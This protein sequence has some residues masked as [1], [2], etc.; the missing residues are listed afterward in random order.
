MML[1]SIAIASMVIG[2]QIGPG[3]DCT[4]PKTPEPVERV[5][6]VVYVG[7]SRMNGMEIHTGKGGDFVVA[8]DCMGYSWLKEAVPYK[9]EQL[10]RSNPDIKEWTIVSN[11]GVNDLHDIEQYILLY[12][13]LESLGF[14]VVVM[15]VNPT[16][17]K[18]NDLN[19]EIDEF[20]SRLKECGVEYFDMCSHLREVGYSTRDGLH[21]DR[22]TNIEIW[23]EL[24]HYL[25][26]ES[27]DDYSDWI[28]G[29]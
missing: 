5:E 21:Y 2:L 28:C 20:N 6:G 14:R 3:V 16:D 15:S 25:Q 4:P 17:G 12:K 24:N 26:T 18:R 11:F 8:K 27:C 23:N 1:K 13:N 9:I 29:N 10:K 22:R 7:D 19:E